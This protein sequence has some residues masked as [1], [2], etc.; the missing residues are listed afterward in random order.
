MT[1]PVQQ[2]QVALDR[3][4]TALAYAQSAQAAIDALTAFPD[5]APGAVRLLFTIPQVR[6]LLRVAPAAGAH[7]AVQA[8]YRTNLTRRASYLAQAAHRITS[9]LARGPEAG[10][11]AVDRE[12]RYL[13][14]HLQADAART[15]AADQVAA[16][17]RTLVRESRKTGSTWNGLLGWHAVMDART[18][19]ECRRANGRNFDPAKLPR[20]GFPGSVHPHCRCRAVPPYDTHLR[21]ENVKP[22]QADLTAAIRGRQAA[23]G[24]QVRQLVP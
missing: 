24:W 1:A 5:I 8:T 12:R 6:A 18:S 4:I 22:D 20:I 13:A 14:Q 17:V 15:V 7:E 2:E 19:A 21:V 3:L 16:Q 9:G 10:L 11:D 23:T